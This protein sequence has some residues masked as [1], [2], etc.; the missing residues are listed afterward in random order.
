MNDEKINKGT[1]IT[2]PAFGHCKELRLNITDWEVAMSRFKEAQN[3]VP[4]NYSSLE[5][6]FQAAWRE[7][8]K[9]AISIGSAIQKARQ[10]VE[11]IKSDIILDEIPKLL[12]ELPKSANNSDFRKAVMARNTDYA[13]A[14]EHLEKL[15]AMLE[16][17]E[18]NM[19]MMENTSRFL[20]KQMDY[21]IRSGV[22]DRG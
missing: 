19:K 16:H 10:N 17:F 14:T 8:K 22:I 21:F 6:C 3:L 9:N 20:K 1:A 5:F 12:E 2:V 13:A 11:E 15:E 18:S 7:S 4:G